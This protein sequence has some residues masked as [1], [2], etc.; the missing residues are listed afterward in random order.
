MATCRPWATPRCGTSPTAAPSTARGARPARG[1]WLR[2]H[3]RA[4][5]IDCGGFT[6]LLNSL[7]SASFAPVVNASDQPTQLLYLPRSLLG[8]LGNV[9]ECPSCRVRL[10][11]RPSVFRRMLQNLVRCL[12]A[13]MEMQYLA[14]CVLVN[15]VIIDDA[16]VGATGTLMDFFQPLPHDF[17][18]A[19]SDPASPMRH[20]APVAAATGE[21]QEATLHVSPTL[22][23]A[24]ALTLSEELQQL[25]LMEELHRRI[26]AWPS[27]LAISVEY[28]SLA[29]MILL[30]RNRHPTVRL[31]AT[32]ALTSMCFKN[33]K[34]RELMMQ[35]P[36]PN[37]PSGLEVLTAFADDE[38]LPSEIRSLAARGKDAMSRR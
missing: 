12:D 22:P 25:Q 6:V 23:L 18:A 5:L 3:A 19:A 11:S 4:S 31:Y 33:D 32:Y 34:H 17:F 10:M 37:E 7:A 35:R 14:G 15:F 21:D 27:T 24:T 29:P 38:T 13:T 28:S 16:V 20:A 9:S 2:R 26:I 8:V 36:V 30:A 1:R